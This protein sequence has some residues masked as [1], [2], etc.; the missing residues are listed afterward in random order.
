MKELIDSHR[1][2]RNSHKVDH[3]VAYGVRIELHAYRMLHPR[4]GNQNPPGRNRSSQAREPGWNEV[5]SLAHLVPSKEHDSNKRGLHKESQ[6]TFNCKRCTEN[7]AYKPGIVTPIGSELKL[8]DQPGGHS[9][10]KI[11]TEKFHP[12]FSRSFPEFIA[13]F[14]IKGLHNGHNNRQTKRERYEDPVIHG[15]QSKLGSRPVNQW[16]VNTFNHIISS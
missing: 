13:C 2:K 14:I 12:E 9:H 5:E 3:L 6:N 11:D 7:I 16:S 10:G 15:C 4:I 1:R 8:Q